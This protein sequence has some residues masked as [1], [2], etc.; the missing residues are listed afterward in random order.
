MTVGGASTMPGTTRTSPAEDAHAEHALE[1]EVQRSRGGRWTMWN[2]TENRPPLQDGL[3][4]SDEVRRL[5]DELELEVQLAV[6]TTRERWRL[7]TARLMALDEELEE[8]GHE[9]T[10]SVED[11]L[12]VLDTLLHDLPIEIN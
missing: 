10:D 6:M 7:V 12:A 9:L 8:S 11:E 3:S 1:R 4:T 2:P 5:A